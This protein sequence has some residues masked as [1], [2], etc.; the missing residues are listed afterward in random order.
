MKRK[1]SVFSMLL[2]HSFFK[3]LGICGAMAATNF[4]LFYANSPDP[5]ECLPWLLDLSPLFWIFVVAFGLMT[6]VL[7]SALCDR[8]GKQNL[9]LGRL[10]M[11][12][13]TIY[14]THVVYHFLCYLLLFAVEA[15]SLL[16]LCLWMRHYVPEQFNHQS[17]MLTCYQSDF[18]HTLFPMSDILGWVTLLSLLLGLGICTAALPTRNRLGKYSISS[19]LMAGLTLLYLQMQREGGALFPDAKILAII[20]T[21]IFALISLLNTMTMEV[22]GDAE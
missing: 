11:S 6:W 21:V 9:F 5:G 13:K 4:G 2:R 16:G 14:L 12:V 3:V 7:C 10:R 20:G 19:F 17:L 22:T 1:L 8:G 18:L 15:L